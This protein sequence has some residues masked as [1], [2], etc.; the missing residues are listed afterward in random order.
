LGEESRHFRAN[1]DGKLRLFFPPPYVP[2]RNTGAL[3]C[4]HGKAAGRMAVTTRTI[5]KGRLAATREPQNEA[6]KILSF[7]QKPSLKYAA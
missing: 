5:S 2:A 6:R 1:A 3:L 4:K 7:F